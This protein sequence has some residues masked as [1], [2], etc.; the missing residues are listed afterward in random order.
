MNLSPAHRPAVVAAGVSQ[1]LRQRGKAVCKV[2]TSH[3]DMAK[4]WDRSNRD[5]RDK[6]TAA[7]DDRAVEDGWAVEDGRVV[8]QDGREVEDDAPGEPLMGP[9]ARHQAAPEQRAVVVMV[10]RQA[11]MPGEREPPVQMAELL[12]DHQ[13]LMPVDLQP[14]AEQVAQERVAVVM[15]HRQ[16][17]LP[18]DLQP[19]AE[20]VVQGQPAHLRPASQ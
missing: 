15:A 1:P 2:T 14:P 20:Q 9:P 11:P 8:V 18:V 13:V 3:K 19:P 12:A 17:L 6:D 10:H 7:P 16:A 5:C 4:R